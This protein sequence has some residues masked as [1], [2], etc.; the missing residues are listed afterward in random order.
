MDKQKILELA[1]RLMLAG[2]DGN[3]AEAAAVCE[4][5]AAELRQ[6]DSGKESGEIL[7][8][9]PDKDYFTGFLKFDKTEVSK[10][11]ANFK[12]YLSAECCTV[13]YRKR[14]RGKR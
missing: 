12:K 1:G 14:V 10:M 13:Y 5:L 2:A 4:E 6:S 11:P 8:P 7:P 9:S 3:A